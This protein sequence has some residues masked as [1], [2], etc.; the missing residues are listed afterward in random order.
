MIARVEAGCCFRILCLERQLVV[1]ILMRKLPR[2][3]ARSRNLHCGDLVETAAFEDGLLIACMQTEAVEMCGRGVGVQREFLRLVEAS[4]LHQEC[5][6][7]RLGILQG[8]RNLDV[9]GRDR[10]PLRFCS[11]AL[12]SRNWIESTQV[13]SSA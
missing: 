5:Q 3:E 6:G 12:A 8:Q 9:I 7:T 2:L 4:L 1:P 10:L 11:L 13:V